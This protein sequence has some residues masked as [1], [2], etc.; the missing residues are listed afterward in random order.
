MLYNMGNNDTKYGLLMQNIAETY[1]RIYKM[2]FSKLLLRC[3][4][5]SM[6]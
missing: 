6:A 2:E 1:L 3:L 5:H 4:L